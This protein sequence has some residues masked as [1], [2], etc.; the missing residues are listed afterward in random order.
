MKM[1][2]VVS[3]VLAGAVMLSLGGCK[4]K[5]TA[6]GDDN[7]NEEYEILWCIP[8]KFG[9]DLDMVNE[10]VNEYVK[11]KIN[12]TVKIEAID[13][14]NY[15]SKVNNSLNAGEKIDI[16]WCNANNY[17][18]R[19]SEGTATD[20]TELAKEYAPKTLD[21]LG[22]KFLKGCYYNGKLYGI[23]A[24]K[25]KA[26][27]YMFFYRKDIAEKYNMDLSGVTSFE[28]LFPFFETIKKNE[29]NMYA[30]GIGDS[31]TPMHTMNYY[32]IG[33]SNLVCFTDEE[34]DTV[35]TICRTEMF[36]KTAEQ[37]RRLN[38]LGYIHPDVSIKE[39]LNELK[40][41]GQVFGWLSQGHS[42][43]LE[44]VQKNSQYPLAEVQ[45]SRTIVD[46]RDAL[47]S[48]MYIPFTCENPTRTM[49]FMELFN[50]DKYLNNLVNFGIEGVHYEKTGEN[51]I[52]SLDKVKDYNFVGSQWVLGNTFINYIFDGYNP[53][54]QEILKKF[55]DEAV[56]SKYYGF[57]FNG[58]EVEAEQTACQSILNEYWKRFAYG[59]CDVD[60]ELKVYQE[61]LKKA[62]I[63]KVL[64]CAQK[65][66]EEWK[67]ISK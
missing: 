45:V 25:D 21:A 47:G 55:N 18:Q 22:E 62:G 3:A 65:Q 17:I 31:G 63:D 54:K 8:G 64:E 37:A 52:K 51:T 49:E 11:D 2:R 30:F 67:K 42:G 15:D 43:T 46:A 1:K 58:E 19:A 29:K 35:T 26:H 40:N 66:Y 12:A 4:D 5:Q 36:K 32:D 61:K 48:V 50:T 6:K 24:N 10:K 39:N 27:N 59:T 53:Q 56:P 34:E 13:W 23:P 20:I 9:T 60:S 44:E 57:M 14:G 33:T 7:K 28:D 41:N 38:E 16:A